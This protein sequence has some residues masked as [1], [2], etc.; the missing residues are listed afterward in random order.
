MDNED[1]QTVDV[2]RLR[3]KIGLVQQVRS[4]C[5][6]TDEANICAKDSRL[7]NTTVF[8]NIANGLR[9]TNLETM[10]DGRKRALVR[11]ACIEANADEY[12][13]K[14]PQGY[15][16]IVG[17]AAG[18]LSGGQRQRLAIARA[19]VANPPILLLDEA[20]SALDPI[21]EESV[22][23]ALD[24]VSKSRTTITIA[25]RLSTIKK[26]D[27]I[28]ILDQGGVVSE[29][30]H[31]SLLTSSGTYADLV[32]AQYLGLPTSS[33]I[34]GRY[35]ARSNEERNIRFEDFRC[36]GIEDKASGASAG[37]IPIE[38]TL[39]SRARKIRPLLVSL[40]ILVKGHYEIKV[41]LCLALTSCIVAG[42]VYPSQ[43]VVFAECMTV[44]GRPRTEWQSQGYF[45]ALMFFILALV[46]LFAFGTMG[47]A[48][49][50][51]STHTA[52]YLGSE[53][54][55]SLL[56][57]EIAFYDEDQ[58]A[59]GS[60]VARLAEHVAQIRSLV[61]S[62]L[63][64]TITVLVN[65]ISCCALSIITDW[66][67]GLVGVFG[68][69]PIVLSTGLIKIKLDSAYSKK[70]RRNT[71]IES[72]Q[73]ASE[74]VDAIRTISS[75]RMEVAVCEN[76]WQKMQQAMTSLFKHLYLTMPL[77]A[78][79]QSVNMLGESLSFYVL[80]CRS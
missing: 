15:D 53:Y 25:H 14:L 43:A 11:N 30:T 27:R 44:F 67:L 35:S 7:F 24:K 73:Y 26:S 18:R 22:Q 52:R 32:N 8:E 72:A 20:T 2:R 79:S 71:F 69:L 4:C 21:V 41:W 78:L 9:G 28:V 68:A 46:V 42:A 60:L 70:Q 76:Y 59:P 3:R 17:H 65:V 61:S 37:Q 45:W 40:A 12:I 10:D 36:K 57:Q 66:R 62:V 75:L 77:F 49:T 13:M 39:P 31:E 80:F 38:D 54:F 1:I 6:H 74:S 16:T 19:I 55:K 33:T 23:S 5:F 51:I 48:F 58:N 64:I 56:G 34:H 63:G 50:L 47:V 29:G